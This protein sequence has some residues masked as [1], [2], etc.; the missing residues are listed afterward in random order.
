M[1]RLDRESALPLEQTVVLHGIPLFAPLPLTAIDRLAAAARSVTFGPG[2]VLMRQGEPGDTYIAIESGTVAIEV[3]GRSVATCGVG[4]GIGEI[5]LLRRVPR[6]ATA[7]AST[8]VT[9]FA[10]SGAG[11]PRGDRGTGHG[12]G[13]PIARRGAAGALMSLRG[14]VSIC[15][16]LDTWRPK[17]HH[18]A[19]PVP[20][21]Q[22]TEQPPSKRKVA[23]SNPAGGANRCLPGDQRTVGISVRQRRKEPILKL[24]ARRTWIGLGLVAAD[25]HRG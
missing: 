16:A 19:R 8:E 24:T 17:S 12:V 14:Q 18:S 3:D 5:A 9:G 11:L 21:A 1:S 22:W 4:E 2:D 20:V 13:R 7:T 23:G 15:A 6:T 10:L 25:R